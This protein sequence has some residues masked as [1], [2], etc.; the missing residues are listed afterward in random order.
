MIFKL[1]KIVVFSGVLLGQI[2]YESQIQPIFNNH[3]LECHV[4]I[5]GSGALELDS[6]E[7]L[8]QGDS[9]NGPVVIPFNADSSLLYRVLL[10]DSVIVPNEPICC[11]MPKNSEPLHFSDQQ[12]I[13][14]WINEGANEFVLGIKSHSNVDKSKILVY[15][16]PFNNTVTIKYEL[17]D[18][19]KVYLAIYDMLGREVKILVDTYE[20]MGTKTIKWNA[21][22]HYGQKVPSGLYLYCMVTKEERK[23]KKL[24]LLN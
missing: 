17:N 23:I 10:P 6:Y 11:R 4:S 18:G 20:T 5:N 9:N 13:Y 2:D 16:N 24:V 3:C 7:Y 8:M 19:G 22:N 15:P 21:D 12:K 1:L 14:N